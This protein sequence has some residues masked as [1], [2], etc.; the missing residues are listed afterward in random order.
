INHKPRTMSA[1]YSAGVVVWAQDEPA[2]QGQ[3]PFMAMNLLPVIDRLVRLAAR[4]ASASPA[5][6]TGKRHTAEHEVLLQQIF[7]G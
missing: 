6:G 4:P 1:H 7:E 5:A 3:W 2:N